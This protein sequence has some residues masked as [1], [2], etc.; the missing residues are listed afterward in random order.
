MT[1]C[2]VT[3]EFFRDNLVGCVMVFSLFLWIPISC[4]CSFRVS[5]YDINN[6]AISLAAMQFSLTM[7]AVER[8]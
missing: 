5:C 8:E 2:F 1:Y 6:I 3:V 7:L 4:I